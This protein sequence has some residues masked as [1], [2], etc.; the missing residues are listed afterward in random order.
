MNV[1]AFVYWLVVA[2]PLSWG[3][4]KAIEKSVPLFSDKE[5]PAAAVAAPAVA[6]PAM[7]ATPS[8]AP[9]A[10]MEATLAPTVAAPPT[11]VPTPT[12]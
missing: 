10:V 11:A 2:L 6:T 1:K 4:Y 9:T 7:V 3:L 8:P 5:A 12:P